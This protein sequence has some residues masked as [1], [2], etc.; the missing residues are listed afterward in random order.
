MLALGDSGEDE[1][2][3]DFL[4]V[5]DVV[6]EEEAFDVLDELTDE[7]LTDRRL[8]LEG[9]GVD[10]KVSLV[11]DVTTIEVCVGC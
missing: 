6:F 8:V 3:V 11:F 1:W 4:V 9:P 5:E 10:L 7:D 2:S